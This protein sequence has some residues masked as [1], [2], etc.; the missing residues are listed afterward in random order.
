MLQI[1][2]CETKAKFKL[3]I[4]VFSI[5]VV[6]SVI[7]KFT[8]FLSML[9]MKNEL[10]YKCWMNTVVMIPGGGVPWGAPLSLLIIL[11]PEYILRSY[12]K[13]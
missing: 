7:E 6:M 4:G 3:T 1:I 12:S 2:T 8:E 11:L 5:L 13:N 9:T 10:R